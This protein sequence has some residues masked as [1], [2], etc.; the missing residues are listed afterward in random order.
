MVKVEAIIRSIYALSFTTQIDLRLVASASWPNIVK[1]K[2]VA[3][4]MTYSVV[5]IM[6]SSC[7]GEQSD[8]E[9]SYG[10]DGRWD[11]KT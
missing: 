2:I 10:G 3:R 11:G 9:D 1:T 4:Q 7:S 8:E 6:S 5:N